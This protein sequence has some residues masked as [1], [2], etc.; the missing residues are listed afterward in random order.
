MGRL[1]ASRELDEVLALT[2]RGGER[3]RERTAEARIGRDRRHLLVELVQQSVF[4]RLPGYEDVNGAEWLCR[5]P[6]MRW[7]G[8]RPIMGAARSARPDGRFETEW[9]ARPE[10]PDALAA[11]LGQWID[12]VHPRRPQKNIVLDMDSRPC[13]RI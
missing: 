3:E 12:N 13:G 1:L 7:V 2:V 4:G 11:L 6:A 9:L 10:N 5:D 8:D